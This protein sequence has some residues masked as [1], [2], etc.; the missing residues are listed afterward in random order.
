MRRIER[1]LGQLQL[2]FLGVRR[3]RLDAAHP[4]KQLLQHPLH[5]LHSMRHFLRDDGV[6][7]V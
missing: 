7:W 2:H 6:S 3:E 1:M 4:Q 5:S